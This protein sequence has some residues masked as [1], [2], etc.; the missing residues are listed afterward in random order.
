MAV[1]YAFKTYFDELSRGVGP[2][3]I[4]DEGVVPFDAVAYRRL[5]VTSNFVLTQCKYI[6]RSNNLVL[7]IKTSFK[8]KETYSKYVDLMQ[9]VPSKYRNSI[10]LQQFLEEAGLI[11]GTAISDINDI[12]KIIDKYNISE[13]YLQYLADLIGLSIIGG[14]EESFKNK[15][16]QLIEA[17][18]WYKRKGT[19]KAFKDISYALDI[20]LNFWD[21]YTNDYVTFIREP[22][23]VGYENENPGGLTSDYY[24]S[25]HFGIDLVLNQKY[26]TGVTSYLFVESMYTKLFQHIE[27]IR[28]I[29]VVNHYSIY[30]NPNTDESGSVVISDGDIKAC[31]NGDWVFTRKNFDNSLSFDDG[32]F[33]DFRESSFIESITKWELGVGNIDTAP[34]SGNTALESSVLS[35]SINTLTLYDDRIEL[36]I[37]LDINTIQDGLTE[38]GI[39]LDDG[40]TMVAQA[41]FPSIQKIE[42]VELRIKFIIRK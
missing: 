12:E 37:I 34:I 26:G 6:A 30:L 39:F 32:E 21:M 18:D 29:N 3:V 24:K 42:G 36:D 23:F 33:F 8:L 9:L 28:P 13:D 14:D 35:G 31:V 19:Y 16:R 22:W 38:M 20:N 1:F 25:P 10:V 2:G 11:I 40:I 5:T 4:F 27:Q 15:R 17:I 7:L 41:T